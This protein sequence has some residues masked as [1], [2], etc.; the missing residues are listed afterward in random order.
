MPV[1]IILKLPS[2]TEDI[3]VLKLQGIKRETKRS[4]V[5]ISGMVGRCCVS[6]S[7]PYL[8]TWTLVYQE[9]K[10]IIVSAE[11]EMMDK[12]SKYY[13]LYVFLSRSKKENIV[14]RRKVIEKILGFSLPTSANKKTWWSNDLY[15]GNSQAHAWVE[16]NFYASN[17]TKDSVTFLRG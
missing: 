3:G 1:R 5:G 14:L 2:Q 11:E 7:I 16:A 17:V 10:I 8:K 12:L 9:Q 4:P 13:R 15:R 6:G